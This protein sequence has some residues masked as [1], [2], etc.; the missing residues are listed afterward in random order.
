MTHRAARFQLNLERFSSSPLAAKLPFTP[1]TLQLAVEA[2]LIQ[3]RDGNFYGMSGEGIAGL[4]ST[5]S[6]FRMTPNGVVTILHTFGQGS[7]GAF[8]MGTVFQGPNGHLYGTTFL[9]GTAGKGI[10]FEIST[11]GKSYA[12]LHNFGD[13]TV[14]NDGLNPT[15]TLI[16]HDH[17]LFGTTEEGGSA[18]LGTV[19]KFHLNP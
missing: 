16:G 7:D 11:N 2:P 13:G 5:P 6:V 17:N 18:G 12:I 3:A 1:Q 9:G 14:P 10:I 15:G 19:F 8:P 4:S